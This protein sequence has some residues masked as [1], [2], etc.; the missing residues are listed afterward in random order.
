MRIIITGGSGLIGS[1]L[2][3][4]L[5]TDGHEVIVLSRSPQ[6][7]TFPPG[8]TGAAWDGQTAVG[9]GHLV[10]GA[11]AIVNLAGESIGGHG[12]PPPR[13]TAER[14]Q[15]IL[16]SRV[17]AGNA[18]TA[19]VEMAAHKPGVVIQA[20]GIDYYGNITSDAEITEAAP[21]GEGFLSDVTEVWEASTAAVEAMGVRRVVTRTGM[22][23]S[24]ESGALPQTM[25][26]YKFFAGG[27]LGSGDQWWPWIHIEDEVRALCFLINNQAAGGAFNLCTPHPLQQKQFGK[28]LGHVMGRPSFVPTPTF[29]LK[30]MLGDMAAIVLHGR[31]ALPS[32]LLA[33]G[34]SFKYPEAHEALLDLLN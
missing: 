10:E 6:K 25:L 20:S 12:F 3:R 16:Q 17:N 5:A 27:P 22:V 18:V 31:R 19:A 21:K 13:W 4:N 8:V 34:F 33:L 11:G 14:K 26:P 2:S 28:V 9:W 23:L 32:R 24:L 1:K 29:A 15:R 30:L 7:Y